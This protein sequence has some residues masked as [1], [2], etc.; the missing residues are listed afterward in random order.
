MPVFTARHTKTPHTVHEFTGTWEEFQKWL[1]DNPGYVQEFKF[2]AMMDSISLGLKKP[3]SR[4]RQKLS[5]IKKVHK[6]STID[7]GGVTEV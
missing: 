7:A 4:F 6:G 3:D 2:P 5:A 1:K